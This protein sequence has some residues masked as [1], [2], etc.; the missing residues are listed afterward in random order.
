MDKGWIDMLAEKEHCTGC[1]AC[2]SICPKSCITMVPDKEGFWYPGIDL[3]SCINCGL[4]EKVCPI[5]HRGEPAREP[6]LAYAAFHR[7]EMIRM[8]SSSGGV[9][10]AF[11]EK[12]IGR[13]GVVFGARFD[14]SF[15]VVHGMAETRQELEAFRG[16]KYVQSEIGNTYKQAKDFLDQSRLVYFS[17]TPCQIGGLKAFLGKEYE[18]LICQDLICHGVPSPKVWEKYV[19]FREAEAGAPVR[20]ISFRDKT[21]GWK[22][23]SLSV[24][25]QN[26]REYRELLDRD[27]YQQAFL[28][29]VDLRPSCY[30]CAFK[31]LRRQS[32]VTLADFWGVETIFPELCDDKGVSLLLVHS[33][34][35][36]H[37]LQGCS[38]GAAG[39]LFLK[40]FDSGRVPALNSA[41]CR[42]ARPNPKRGRFFEHL[43]MQ[44]FDA[45]MKWYGSKTG[46]QRLKEFLKSALRQ[47]GL[48]DLAKEC[49]HKI[50][51]P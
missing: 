31:S 51:R 11:A 46:G 22:R 35:G 41:V 28:N 42:S 29:N 17:G 13:G 44:D 33:E 50:T 48:F 23:F 47:L 9:F 25:F 19:A 40:E 36:C 3:K 8:E 1:S 12:V 6:P 49:F 38:S 30:K 10:I 18:N 7:D 37:L 24:R 21:K 16:S 14:D 5:L 2:A 26:G 32:D 4:C 43:G 39:G 34:K 15:H 20:A 27:S 45:F